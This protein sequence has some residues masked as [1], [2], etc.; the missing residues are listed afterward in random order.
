M[1]TQ[2]RTLRASSLTADHCG[3]QSRPKSAP[4]LRVRQEEA[5]S[6]ARAHAAVMT[7]QAFPRQAGAPRTQPQGALRGPG[8]S[9]RAQTERRGAAAFTR[10]DFTSR[11]SS[12]TAGSKKPLPVTPRE[13]RRDMVMS[14]S[15]R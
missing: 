10:A 3:L 5:P 1:G 11:V 9:D 6:G 12:S 7:P 2:G 14:Y 8:E 13:K 15:S 4:R